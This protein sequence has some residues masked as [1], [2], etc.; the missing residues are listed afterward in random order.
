MQTEVSVIG[1]YP[2]SL[3]LVSM[4]LCILIALYYYKL[5]YIRLF[6]P[7]STWIP[8]DPKLSMT[9]ARNLKNKEGELCH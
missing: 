2:S 7:A 6:I 4:K 1:D 3:P 9:S 8:Q 5:L